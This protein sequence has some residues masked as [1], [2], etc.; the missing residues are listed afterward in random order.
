MENFRKL[1]ASFVLSN[2]NVQ[3]ALNEL[4]NAVLEIPESV[5]VIQPFEGS[6]VSEIQEYVSDIENMLI[7]AYNKGKE[8][9]QENS[10]KPSEFAIGVNL[11]VHSRIYGHEFA[12]GQ[13]VEI[14]GHDSSYNPCWKCTDGRNSWWLSDEEASIFKIVK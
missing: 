12:I 1:A 14:V 6:E 4:D 3:E 8:Y 9:V 5:S 2:L 11:E 7:H 13:I 10:S